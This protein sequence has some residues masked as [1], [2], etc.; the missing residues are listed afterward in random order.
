MNQKT[1]IHTVLGPIDPQELGLTLMHEHIFINDIPGWWQEPISPK[2][3]KVADLPVTID[4]LGYLRHN[5]LGIKDNLVMDNAAIARRELEL[6]KE[7]G[8]SALLELSIIGLYQDDRRIDEIARISRETGVHVISGT[9]FYLDNSVPNFYKEWGVDRLAETI[10]EEIQSGIEGGQ[11]KAGIIGEVGTSNPIMP[12]EEKS[13]IASAIAQAET[14]AAISV[15]V[16]P[17]GRE[18]NKVIEILSKAG[19]DLTR[20]IL[21]HMDEHL[22]LDYHR[23]LA[24]YGVI[25]EFD[26]FGAEWYYSSVNIAE[27][28][29]KE[30]IAAL[31]QLVAEGYA[32]QIV[33]SH[34]VW[35]KQCLRSYGGMGYSHIPEN[36]VP[37]LRRVGVADMEIEQM[38]IKNPRRLLQ[39]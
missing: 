13:L 29:D 15:H 31:T 36:I 33:L 1:F 32:P 28:T 14:G 11:V 18:G 27:P 22:D 7:A 20:V 2:D 26:T 5:P 6:Y 16:A 8:G 19:A 12:F 39:F 38:L 34:D 30:R 10:I 25:L 24:D 4:Q 35:L 17:D 37:W 3:K 23:E 9:G 21:D